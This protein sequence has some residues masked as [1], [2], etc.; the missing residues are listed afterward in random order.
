MAFLSLR[1]RIREAR[2]EAPWPELVRVSETL[3]KKRNKSKPLT[4]TLS[5]WERE[6]TR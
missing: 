5:Q 3:G 2:R 1:E 4:P 6:K